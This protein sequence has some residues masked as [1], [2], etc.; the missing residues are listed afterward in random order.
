MSLELAERVRGKQVCAINNSYEL[1]P[2]ADVLVANDESWW[3]RHPQAHELAGKKFSAN[4]IKGVERVSP[5]SFGA[6]SNSGVLAMDV[7]R[8]LGATSIV[9]LG[10]DMHGTHFF[11]P[12]TNGCGN[13]E[14]RRRR[15]HFIQYRIWAKRNKSIE[16][17][18]CTE[19]SALDC[20]PMGSLD[21]VLRT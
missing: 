5:N 12:Y 2:W 18:N 10:F 20:F 11:G 4:R 8:N 21:E 3:R 14:P 13:T 1:A 15:V 6:Q 7:V 19:G 16:V 17:L 9:L